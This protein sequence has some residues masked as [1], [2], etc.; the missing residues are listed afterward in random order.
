MRSTSRIVLALLWSTL[1][2][3]GAAWAGGDYEAARLEAGSQ[4][5]DLAVSS[6]I[7]QILRQK[8]AQ[9]AV[10]RKEG[11]SLLE[12][13]LREHGVTPETAE[14]IFQLAELKWEE[15][16]ANFLSEMAVYNAAVEKCAAASKENEKE[17]EKEKEKPEKRGRRG[18]IRLAEPERCKLPAQPQLDLG[19]SQ[20]L[21]ARLINEY[22]DFRKIDAVLYLYGFS[23]RSEGKSAEALLLFKKILKDH[24][25]SRFR[26]D[27]WMAVAEARFYEEGD[28]KR[29]LE[30][31]DEVLKYPDSPLNDLAL[32]KTAWCYW[33]LG[34]SDAA[35]KRFKEVLDLG[36]G[37]AGPKAHQITKEGKKRLEELKGEALEYLVQVFT[38]DERKG[39][40]D[41]FDFL[42]SIGGAIYSRK[43]IAKLADTF[44]A[45]ARYERAIESERFLI[46]LDPADPECPDRQKRIVEAYKEMDENKSAVTELRKLAETYGAGDTE[47]AKAQQDKGVIKHA[48][49]M[50]AALLRNVAKELHAEA[51]H[52]EEVQ[53]YV[54]PNRYARAADAYSYYLSKFGDDSDAVEAHYLLGDIYFFKLKKYEEAGDE[55]L[56]VGKSKPVGKLHKEA[57][58]QSI[59][60]YEKVRQAKAGK[61]LIPSDKKMGEAIDLY[62]TLYPTDPEIASILVK[63]GELFFDRGDYDEAVKRFGLIVEKYPKNPAAGIAGDK[64]LES[65]NKAKDYSNVEAWARR[66]LKVPAFQSKADQERLSKLVVDAGM[67]SGEQ[68]AEKEPLKAA[69]TYQRVAAEFPT[70]SRATQAL[71]NAAVTYTRGGKPEEA[72]KVYGTLVEKYPMSNEAAAAAWSAGKLYEQAAL[73]DQAA[74]YYEILADKFP[75]DQHAADALFNAGLLREHLGDPKSAINSYKEY[76]SRYKTRDDVREVAFRVGVVYAENGQKDQAAKAFLEFAQKYPGGAQAIQALSRAGQALVE[77]GQERRAEEPL[78]KAVALFKKS[79]DKSDKAAANAAA[80]ARYL[81]GEIVFHQFE[82]LKLA[83]E[84]K[85]LKK[86]LDEKSTLLDKSKA[87]YIDVVTFGDPEWATAGL[88]R[89]GEAYERFSKALRDTPTPP[90]LNPEEQQ[91]Y[92]DELEKVVV[93]VEEKAIDAYKGGYQKALQLGVYNDFTH[94]LRQALGRLDD[95]EFPP[96]AESRARPAAAEPREDLPFV[97][98]VER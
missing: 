81:Q 37:K 44:Y 64:I 90:G 56:S 14:V 13:Y 41:A 53:K 59:S 51:Q 78:E 18:A 27:A 34:D 22:P 80:H 68:L 70:S 61:G 32:F 55:Y 94:K 7:E 71:T 73:W 12:V 15:S 28:Y 17:K 79:T 83:S 19:S 74:R 52:V 1:A 10:K 48:H 43:V 2:S 63:N 25:Q 85:R 16:K 29:A 42:A 11:I 46:N 62:A 67:K 69:E 82:N 49:E 3:S 24:P 60:S 39:P 97:G 8:E 47:W 87:V 84:P 77:L 33:K 21:Y 31:Y 96:E 38:E 26:P 36:S 6:Q 66:L 4:A 75:K 9:V 30:G 57:L 20:K 58:L 40:K 23:L 45:Q 50:I 5:R 76:A 93:V 98:S 95:Q 91:V 35:A 86:T 54:D 72:V 92:R 89:I 88:Y 65:L